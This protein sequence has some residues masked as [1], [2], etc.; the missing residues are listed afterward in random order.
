MQLRTV[1]VSHARGAGA[2]VNIASAA[3]PAA[4]ALTLV[5]QALAMVVAVLILCPIVG[6]DLLSYPEGIRARTTHSHMAA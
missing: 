6:Q 4:V 2:G 5:L 1:F 3:L